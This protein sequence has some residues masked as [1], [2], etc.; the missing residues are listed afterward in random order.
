M[1][2]RGQRINNFLELGC[3]VAL[4][5]VDIWVSSPTFQ[6]SNI[7][8]P[9][10]PSTEKVL[11]FNLRF[12][13]SN[14][15]SCFQNIKKKAEFINLDDSEVLSSDF[16]C[17]KTSTASLTSSA[18]TTSMASTTSTALFYQRTYWFWWLDHPWNQKCQYWPL[19]VEWIIKDPTLHWYLILFFWRLFKPA[20]VT[21]HTS[22]NH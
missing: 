6:K 5:G 15:K 3:L 13:D 22:W 16:P 12:H 11:K 18:S 1:A 9:Q 20:D 7:C 19:F 17:L 10:Q 8:C 21:F 2:M 4:G 14:Q